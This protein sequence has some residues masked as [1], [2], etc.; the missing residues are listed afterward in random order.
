MVGRKSQSQIHVAYHA[1]QRAL[2]ST[3]SSRKPE[4]KPLLLCSCATHAPSGST[5][6]ITEGA[7]ERQVCCW[8]W[9]LLIAD[10]N[11]QDETGLPPHRREV[12]RSHAAPHC[13]QHCILF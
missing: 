9:V 7:N 6:C 5:R 8:S 11:G 13:S 1:G 10:A 2:S 4:P 12:E 3:C